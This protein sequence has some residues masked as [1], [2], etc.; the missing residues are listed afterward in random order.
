MPLDLALHTYE[1]KW[2]ILDQVATEYMMRTLRALGAF[3]S[4][5]EPHTVDT[6]MESCAIVPTYRLLMAR[7]LKNLVAEDRLKHVGGN[8]FSVDS[9]NEL[10]V[11]AL[12]SE[13]KKQ[14]ADIPFIW[15]Y[16]ER[17][18]AMA[19][20]VLTGKVSA[21]ET[22]F[23][24]GSTDFA[25]QLYEQWS[26]SRYFNGIVRAA[27]DGGRQEL[28]GSAVAL[29]RGWRGHRRHDRVD[30][31]S[32]ASRAGALLFYRRFGVLFQPRRGEI[33][34]LPV[35]ALRSPGCWKKIRRNKATGRTISTSS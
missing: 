22:L 20:A 19:A 17:C 2:R 33:S 34:R 21:L 32:L 7:W 10:T 16:L 12:R 23:P 27:V 14:L 30:P 26:Y 4:A 6:L 29:H 24:G 18:G 28:A 15:E 8:Y 1:A 35:R 25:E 9:G 11:D 13:A 3:T 5:R 31:A